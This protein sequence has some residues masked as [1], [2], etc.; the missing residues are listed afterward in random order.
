MVRLPDGKAA[1]LRDREVGGARN[2]G[3][4]Q[5]GVGAAVHEPEGLAHPVFHGHARPGKL[6]AH[7]DQL[8]AEHLVERAAGD[9]PVLKLRSLTRC[10]L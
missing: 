4:G 6:G 3:L 1:L 9:E 10:S 2:E 8:E 5:R 7:L